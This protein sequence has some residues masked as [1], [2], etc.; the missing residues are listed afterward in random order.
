[1][2]DVYTIL[3]EG[4]DLSLMQPFVADLNEKQKRFVE[5]ITYTIKVANCLEPL[6]KDY[7]TLEV[8]IDFDD[9]KFIVDLDAL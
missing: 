5:N 7:P 6:S 1:M 3:L 8:T 2:Y 9:S 4:M